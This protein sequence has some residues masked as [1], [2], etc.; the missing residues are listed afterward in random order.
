[1]KSLRI[2]SCFIFLIFSSCY[3]LLNNIES[4]EYYNCVSLKITFE[5]NPF[6]NNPINNNYYQWITVIGSDN[7]VILGRSFDDDG[8]YY[9]FNLPPGEYRVLSSKVS[10]AI[11]QNKFNT[12]LGRFD[13]KFIESSKFTI[14]KNEF[15]FIGEFFC[16]SNSERSSYNIIAGTSTT[17]TEYDYIDS[18][19]D[20]INIKSNYEYIISEFDRGIWKDIVLKKYNMLYKK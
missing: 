17:N 18:K 5:K 8:Y 4:N 15:T 1:M 3:S 2:L 12:Y 13:S 19:T 10:L 7:Q 20:L 9:I 11:G 14:N 16:K 6:Q